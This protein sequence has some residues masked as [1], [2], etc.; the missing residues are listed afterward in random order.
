[1]SSQY[2]ELL[3]SCG[4]TGDAKHFFSLAKELEASDNLRMAATAYDR[5]YGLNPENHEIATAR[6]HI[7]E[8][9]SVVEHGIQF[10][11]I[12]AG[13]FLMGSETGESDEQPVHAIE[14]SD[15]WLSEKPI[16]W[17]IYCELMN[18]ELP[19][20][21]A[22]TENEPQNHDMAL[23]SLHQENKIR[24]QYCEN[25]TKHATDWHA[26]HPPQEWERAGKRVSSQQIFGQPQRENPELPWGYDKKP[27]VCVS[28][29]AAEELCHKISTDKIRYRLS[30]EAEWEKAA[31][32]GLINSA[33]PWGNDPPDE[34]RCDFNRFEQFSILPIHRF[35][36]NGYHLYAMSG[37]V[38]EWT[39]D[40]YDALY[41][42]ESPRLN[43]KGPT[44]GQEKV[45][46]G[47]S[48]TDCADVLSVSFRMSR[49]AT[50]WRQESWG[51]HKAPNIGFRLCRERFCV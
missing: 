45:L 32:G 37:S 23:F 9:L 30:T 18:W 33:Y 35:S 29:Q 43:P 40:W 48:W 19:P 1:M 6:K 42:N 39:S 28:W 11:Y 21:A 38:W 25:E 26:H 14:L 27:M 34:N 44:K 15:F 5:A 10:R 4:N 41:Y 13:A 49:Q 31:R 16:S 12:P 2:Q 46:R 50:Y 8:Q 24:L 17:A 22:P 3:S 7:L 51:E 47:G 20:E 36:P